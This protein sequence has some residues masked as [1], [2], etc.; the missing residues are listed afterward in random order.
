MKLLF[1]CCFFVFSQPTTPGRRAPA[2]YLRA[3]CYTRT[4]TYVYAYEACAF[5][6]AVAHCAQHN[7][8]GIAI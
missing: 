1:C 3:C 4:F 2:N 5:A 8:S 6:M 7:D